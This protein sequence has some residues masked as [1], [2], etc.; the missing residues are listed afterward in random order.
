VRA[1]GGVCKPP[2]GRQRAPA[3]VEFES[4]MTTRAD[5][6]LQGSAQRGK[7]LAAHPGDPASASEA[8]VG[9]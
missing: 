4:P 6:R 8:G 2:D 3:K 1:V 9:D 5:Q 7:S